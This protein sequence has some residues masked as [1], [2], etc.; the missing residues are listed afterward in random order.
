MSD[1]VM[2][3]SSALHNEER[4]PS[5]SRGRLALRALCSKRLVYFAASLSQLGAVTDLSEVSIFTLVLVDQAS[6]GHKHRYVQV[7]WIGGCI[8]SALDA[9]NRCISKG[10]YDEV[11]VAIVDRSP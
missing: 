9:Q 7:V 8:S 4:L 11:T 2:D 1:I 10:E 5:L 3:T 6:G